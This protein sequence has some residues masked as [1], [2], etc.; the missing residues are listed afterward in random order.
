MLVSVTTEEVVLVS[1]TTEEVVLVSV[2][3]SRRRRQ[4]RS[5][6]ATRRSKGR[7]G[8]PPR[9]PL[10]ARPRPCFRPAEAFGELMVPAALTLV[11]VDNRGQAA[12]KL[13]TAVTL[14]AERT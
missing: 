5:A 8:R 4:R 13:L 2:T 1:V 3:I 14:S 11:M 12:G 7:G 9:P 10:A 6:A